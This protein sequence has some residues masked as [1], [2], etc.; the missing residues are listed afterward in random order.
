MWAD[1][2]NKIKSCFEPSN[3]N[4]VDWKTLW[5]DFASWYKEVFDAKGMVIWSEQKRQ[6]ETLMLNQ[7]SDLNKQNFV[8]AYLYQG[9]PRID[10]SEMTYWEAVRTKQNLEGDVNGVGGDE[11]MDKIT[12]VNLNKLIQ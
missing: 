4:I 8:L 1:Q 3:P 11:R 10:S 2:M 9:K 12:I 7:L 6:I 5:K